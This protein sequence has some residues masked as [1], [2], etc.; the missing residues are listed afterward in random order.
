MS[1]KRAAFREWYRTIRRD[2][3]VFAELALR[4]DGEHNYKLTDQQVQLLRCAQQETLLPLAQRKKRIAVKSGQ[5]TGKSNCETILALWR[6]FWAVD[7][8]VVVT[9]PTMN[10]IRDVWMAEMRR[11]LQRA[12][13]FIRRMVELTAMK[14]K[15]GGRDTWGIWAKAASKP[16][17]FQGFHHQ[18]LTFIVDEASGIEREIFKVIKGTLTNENSL[19]VCAGNP[20]A[21]DTAFYDMYFKPSEAPLWHKFTFNSEQ[22]PITDKENLRRIAQE[23]GK[24]SDVYRVRVLGEFPLADLNTV[25]S[26]SDLWACVGVPMREAAMMR[27]L[28]T[29]KAIGID[30][31]RFGSDESTI[32]RRSGHAIVE[33]KTFS[34]TEPIDVVDEAFAMQRRAGWRDGDCWF[35]VDAG[36]IGQGVLGYLHRHKK[37]VHEFHTQYIAS[38]RDYANKLTEAY[39]LVAKLARER[40]MHLPDDDI[41]VEQLSG[42]LYKTDAKGKLLLEKK[43]DYMKRNEGQSPDRADGFV[44][45]FYD[46]VTARAKV[47]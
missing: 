24:N 46:A 45:A 11:M 22:T 19:L 35:V 2:P 44:L 27:G 3:L 34:K 41:L 14:V 28:R 17:N 6:A 21:R 30:F 18:F 1:S 47:V 7:A 39:F 25:V 43:D 12:H 36:G 32:Y 4:C 31:A 40:R 33:W 10:Q 9:A 8:L 38:Q 15:I 26:S 29:A 42:R 5:G 16:E 37:R 23:F 20:N 13:P